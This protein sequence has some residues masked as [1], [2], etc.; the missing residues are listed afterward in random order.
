MFLLIIITLAIIEP[1][2]ASQALRHAT[3]LHLISS[4]ALLN[5][6]EVEPHFL[7][8][9]K[10]HKPGPLL[11]HWAPRKPLLIPLLAHN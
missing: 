11:A 7:A 6:R 4:P 2:G 10:D 9:L 8:C 5:H 3:S 1:A